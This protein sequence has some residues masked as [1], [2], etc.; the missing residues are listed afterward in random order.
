MINKADCNYNSMD[1]KPASNSQKSN[2]EEDYMY[3]EE[4]GVSPLHKYALNGDKTNLRKLLDSVESIDLEVKDKFGKT[5]LIFSVIGNHVECAIILLKSGARVDNSDKCGQTALHW[6]AHKGLRRCVRLLLDNG[7][8]W[9]QKDIYG[10]TPLHLAARASSPKCLE[11]I[12]KEVQFGQTD[13]E[14]SS[15]KTP[16]HWS[17]AFGNAKQIKILLKKGANIRIPD[18][19]GKT[20]LHLAAGCNEPGALECVKVLMEEAPSV[21]NWQ[22]Y[23]GRSALHVAVALGSTDIV[24]LL[25]STERCNLNCPI[26]CF[27]PLCIGQHLS[28]LFQLMLLISVS[29]FC[30][31]ILTSKILQEMN[32]KIN[33]LME[34][35][36]KLESV[37]DCGN[38]CN[39]MQI[40]TTLKKRVNT[41]ES[42]LRKRNLVL[43]NVEMNDRENL[44]DTVSKLIWEVVVET[45]REILSSWKSNCTKLD[46]SD[47]RKAVRIREDLSVECREKRKEQMDNLRQAR[48]EGEIA[49]FKGDK[50]VISENSRKVGRDKDEDGCVSDSFIGIIYLTKGK[51][52]GGMVLMID[53]ELK[54]V[55]VCP[56]EDW[57]FEKLEVYIKCY[58]LLEPLFDSFPNEEIYL[59]GNF[60]GRIGTL[61]EMEWG[62]SVFPLSDYSVYRN[63]EDKCINK[64]GPKLCQVKGYLI[65]QLNPFSHDAQ[66]WGLA[67]VNNFELIHREFL[68]KMLVSDFTHRMWPF[69]GKL[70]GDSLPRISM[71]G[72]WMKAESNS[73]WLDFKNWPEWLGFGDTV[74]EKQIDRWKEQIPS[75]VSRCVELELQEVKNVLNSYYCVVKPDF[76]MAEETNFK[77]GFRLKRGL[78]DKVSLLLDRRADFHSTDINGATPLHY[79]SQGNYADTVAVFLSRN[80]ITDKRDSEG[81]NALMWAA[82]RGADDVIRTIY[83]FGVDLSLKDENGASALHA[84]ASQGNITTID[85]LLDLG[86]PLEACDKNDMTP[87]LYACIRGKAKSVRLLIEKGASLMSMDMDGRTSLHWAALGGHAY[88]CQILLQNGCDPNC[89]DFYGRTPLYCASHEGHINCTSVLLA[90]GA[91]PNVADNEGK[92]PLHVACLNGCLDVVR[93]LCEYGVH[94]NCMAAV[95]KRC[96]P[97]DYALKSE[98][99]EIAQILIESG[100]LTSMDIETI[101]AAVIQAFFK[102]FL[103]R[104]QITARKRLFNFLSLKKISETSTGRACSTG[105]S[106]CGS[107]DSEFHQ[108][109]NFRDLAPLFDKSFETRPKSKIPVAVWRNGE[110]LRNG[111][112]KFMQS[113]EQAKHVNWED[114]NYPKGCTSH[115]YHCCTCHFKLN[116]SCHNCFR[117]SV[118]PTKHGSRS[119][120]S[121]LSKERPSAK[122]RN[123]AAMVIQRAWKRYK[124]CQ[125]IL[126]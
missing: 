10:V 94:V 77:F 16:L 40:I 68:K 111:K 43:F 101:A 22:D 74:T 13:I 89:Q 45:K 1:N 80:Y 99:T 90:N 125:A 85:M 117:F 4:N 100:G 44:L 60:N 104:K 41:H 95:N 36:N 3:Y 63:S 9:H 66:V 24:D 27:V 71:E 21:I 15:K 65:Q 33:I 72:M 56:F 70:D 119:F 102:G 81:R 28:S 115:C 112:L 37:H 108:S 5:P 7:A 54:A 114:I 6:A 121:L 87:F 46:V 103:I 93:L 67:N 42:N 55:V 126:R 107:S 25:T 38:D 35:I 52:R 76:G 17:A 122:I 30:F 113:L 47:W 20:P 88:V 11:L 69:Y 91:N 123:D 120:N 53:K 110:K 18:V 116:K 78:A 51:K 118:F 29:C 62:G 75:I 12:S 98:Q 79:A 23:E 8:L 64:I 106:C 39:N 2:V 86:A 82:A 50:L 48:K 61:N 58:K 59:L 97:L 96:T 14:D 31:L 83:T 73:W 19:E 92:I 105:N 34:R 57:L 26:I 84:A 32:D 109:S 124:K 49:Y